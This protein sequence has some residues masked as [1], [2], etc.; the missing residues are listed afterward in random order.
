MAFQPKY[1]ITPKLLG[2]IIETGK[3]CSWIELASIQMSWLSILQKANRLRSAYAST[4]IEGNP[5]TCLQVQALERGEKTGALKA[6]EQEVINYKNTLFWIEKNFGQ[7]IT[8]TLLGKMHKMIMRDLLEDSRIGKYKDKQNFILNER[9]ERIYLPTSPH[10]TPT[11]VK[12][13]LAWLHS[14]EAHKLHS[15]L[16]YAIFH[17]RLV[18]I[19]PF[20]DG[21]GRLARALGTMILYQREFD[22]YPIFNLDEYFAQDRSR[23]FRT[24]QQVRELNGDL[25]PWIDYIGEALVD[26]LR[27]TRN[28]IENM[29]VSYRTKIKL[30]PRQEEILRLLRDNNHIRANELIKSLGVTR[31]RINQILTPLIDNNLVIKEGESR[32]TRY[33]LAIQ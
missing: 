16:V 12:E 5:L 27:V 26:T 7:K 15:I 18:S 14:G 13:L 19:H 9:N 21:N 29:Q 3:L 22:A 33:K 31:A 24:I 30:S 4:A 17:H 8:E 28:R 11:A 1:Q 2:F 23:Y 10:E 6:Q 20:A 25:T 32:A